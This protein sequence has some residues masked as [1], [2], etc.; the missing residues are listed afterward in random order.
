MNAAEALCLAREHGV[1]VG[2]AGTDLILDANQEPE[3]HV[4]EALRRH[5]AG[6][7]TLLAADGWT[8]E[9]WRV[10][11]DERAGILEFDGELS[12]PEAE[13]RTFECCLVEWLNR[14]PQPSDPGRCAWCGQSEEESDCVIVPPFGTKN[15]GHTWLHH[16]CWQDWSGQR[17]AE[18][19]QA[20]TTLGIGMQI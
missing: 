8:A 15:H 4:L 19:E 16:Y 7:V 17:R 9:D 11:Y 20:L 2:V 10:F 3:S 13:A 18:A 6:I 5:K 12:R 1:H 14:H